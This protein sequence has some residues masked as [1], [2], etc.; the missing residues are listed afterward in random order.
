MAA[1]SF[2]PARA[3]DLGFIVNLIHVDTVGDSLEQPD[4]PLHQRYLDALAKMS[5]DPQQRLVIAELEGE[6]I[7]TLQLTFIPGIARLGETRCLV[8]AVH[9]APA[10]RSRGYG[11][12]MIQWAVELAREQGC[13]LV[14][15]TSNKAR[16]DAHRFYRRLGFAQSH[17]G[18]KLKL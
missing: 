18:F 14:Q 5:A 13:G 4:E 17:E 7:G 8:E 16:T 1:L 6:R 2:R 10:H 11:G 15:L 12:A 9:I 3:D